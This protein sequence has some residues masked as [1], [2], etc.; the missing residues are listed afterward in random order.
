M[1]LELHRQGLKV[2]AIA[3]Q[4]GVDRNRIEGLAP[5]LRDLED[6][7]R[8]RWSA[9]S[10]RNCR[11]GVLPSLAALVTAGTAEPVCFSIQHGVQ[12]LF[13][14]ATHHLSL[15]QSGDGRRPWRGGATNSGNPHRQATGAALLN[16]VCSWLARTRSPGGRLPQQDAPV[17]R[18][19][20]TNQKCLLSPGEST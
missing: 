17:L 20:S 15:A 9:A 2:A 5:Q 10:D 16:Q 18:E 4:L 8:R 7:P 6:S 13:H 14:R 12:R 19:S 3:R 11:P 1:I